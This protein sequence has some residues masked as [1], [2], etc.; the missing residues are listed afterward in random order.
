MLMRSEADGHSRLHLAVDLEAAL[1]AAANAR[2][3]RRDVPV[4][5]LAPATTASLVRMAVEEWGMIA[6]LWTAMIFSPWWVSVLLVLPLAGRFHALGVILHDATH[7]PLRRKTLGVRFVEALCGFPIASTLNAMRYH[8]LRHH[9]DSG[10]HSDPYYKDGRQTASWWTLNTLRGVLLVP[11]WTLRACVGAVAAVV[12]AARNVYAHI[13]LQDKTSLDLR[14]NREVIDCARAE[15]AQVVFQLGIAAFWLAY[16][17]AVLWGYVIPVTIAGLFAARRVLIEHTYE[18]TA[19]RQV[20]TIIAT[21][22]DNHLGL[23]GAL[24]LAPRNIGYHI[25]HH[26]H[27][28]VSL[29][30]LPRL[31]EWYA[32]SYPELYPAPRR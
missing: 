4:E 24:G 30:A 16:P 7:M 17:R 22:N 12:P 3:S 26:I 27:P 32:R 21:T 20:E 31:R 19:D 8:H 5:L 13:F 9:R 23:L 10:M 11:F 1:D 28:Q 2:L 18:R 6:A 25:V 14:A 29:K 15:V